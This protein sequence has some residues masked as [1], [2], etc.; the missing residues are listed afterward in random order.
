[1]VSS[2]SLANYEQAKSS[3]LS[4]ANKPFSPITVQMGSSSHANFSSSSYERDGFSTNKMF[5]SSEFHF[6]TLLRYARS[7]SVEN[8]AEKLEFL[9]KQCPSLP[10]S[11]NFKS[12]FA[13]AASNLLSQATIVAGSSANSSNGSSSSTLT[14]NLSTTNLISSQTQA[15]SQS[16][17][18]QS[19][20][21]SPVQSQQNQ[22]QPQQQQQQLQQ[23]QQHYIQNSSH[24][25][26]H[27]HHAHNHHHHHHHH[28]LSIKLNERSRSALIASLILIIENHYANKKGNIKT[29][30]KQQQHHT[31][32]NIDSHASQLSQDLLH[33]FLIILENLPNLKWAE[34]PELLHQQSFH[35]SKI[36][37]SPSS[38]T[39]G[40]S[41]VISKQSESFSFFIVLFSIKFLSYLYALIFFV[42]EE[43]STCETFM[44]IYNTGLT[45]LAQIYPLYRSKILN[46]QY[47]LLNELI[48]SLGNANAFN[49]NN[50]DIVK[51][52]T[53]SSLVVNVDSNKACKT[54]IPLLVGLL[55]SI[56]RYFIH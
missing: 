47:K 23:Q 44:F 11:S 37:M 9:L 52:I 18:Q 55:R 22:F 5:N 40:G 12:S 41:G 48:K 34:E 16:L 39:S 38:T 10:S 29:N 19:Q 31:E 28:N 30:S 25:A 14:N 2:A 3:T 50:I 49:L 8:Y 54:L 42:Y 35:Q 13:S 32:K 33:Y 15:Q 53:T 17:T 36:L 46:A 4:N 20:Q 21:Q 43:L 6:R 27:Y 26:N 56:G 45:E 24:Q 7:G 51:T 1:M